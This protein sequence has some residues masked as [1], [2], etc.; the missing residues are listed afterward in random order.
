MIRAQYGGYS[1]T[2]SAKAL[3]V[4]GSG[5]CKV[6]AEYM[7]GSVRMGKSDAIEFTAA[8]VGK[9]QLE[10]TISNPQ[11]SDLRIVIETEDGTTA[12]LNGVS[13]YLK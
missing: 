11:V 10:F 4:T 8:D 6:Y 7:Y 9:K 5:K 12:R 1:F 2:L 3:E 13:M